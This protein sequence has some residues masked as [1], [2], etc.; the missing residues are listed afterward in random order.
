MKMDKRVKKLFA[1][2]LSIALVLP[3]IPAW[4]E[5]QGAQ[6][7]AL[8]ADTFVP[9]ADTEYIPIMHEEVLPEGVEFDFD[10][11]T[12]DELEE[13]GPR[14]KAVMDRTVWKTIVAEQFG[15]DYLRPYIK[16][17]GNEIISGSENRLTITE[18]DLYLPGKNGLDLE[19]KRRY[20]SGKY[21]AYPT[22]VYGGAGMVDSY[23]QVY[24]YRRTDTN[25]LIYIGFCTEDERNIYLKND[26]YIARL[27][28]KKQEE[29]KGQKYYDFRTLAGS[30][31]DASDETAVHVVYEPAEAPWQAKYRGE[32]GYYF[33]D[34]NLKSSGNTIGAGW[35]YVFPAA[36]IC[37]DERY[38]YPS[39]DEKEAEQYYS[40]IFQDRSGRVNS[41]TMGDG[42]VIGQEPATY[43][44]TITSENNNT[45]FYENF[46]TIQTLYENG[47]K[48]NYIIT[49][50]NGIK[51][52]MYS[53]GVVTES[54]QQLRTA[55]I[56]D[57]Y[58]NRIIFEYADDSSKTPNKIIDTYGREISIGENGIS[59]FNPELNQEQTVRYSVSTLP[60]E[61]LPNNSINDNKPVQ[62]LT[63][64]NEKGESTSYDAR[65]MQVIFSY[66]GSSHS[67]ERPMNFHDDLMETAIGYTL[68][69]ILYPTGAEVQYG[70]QPA[71]MR[72]QNKTIRQALILDRRTEL[73]NG[74]EQNQDTYT[75]SGTY[76]GL[77]KTKT[78]TAD[79][80]EI[81][82]E[83]DNNGLLEEQ[84]VYSGYTK[85]S[86]VT[87]SYNTNDL[88]L[89]RSTE[90]RQG[91][92]KT[93]EYT[94][95]NQNQISAMTVG[96]L[97]IG[98]NYHKVNNRVTDIPK[99]ITYQYK[100]GYYFRTDYTTSTALVPGK[101][102]VDTVKTVKSSDVK[103]QTKYEYDADGNVTAVYTWTEDKNNDGI[104]D[105]TDAYTVVN[106]SYGLTP[107]K[108]VTIRDQV[109]N[110]LDADGQNQGS[111]TADY[112]FNIFG[113]PTAR[114]DPYQQTTTVTYDELNRPVRYTFPNGGT[115]TIEYNLPALY[116]TVTD[117]QGVKLRYTYDGWGRVKKKQRYFNGEWRTFE[118]Y[119]YDAAGRV[120]E[121]RQYTAEGA[122]TETAYTYDGLDRVKTAAVQDLSGT[123]LYTE[124]YS[125]ENGRVITKTTTPADGGAAAAVSQTYDSQDRLI[126]EERSSGGTTY[127][128]KY[129]YDYQGRLLTEEDANGNI[130]SYTYDWRGNVIQTTD[131]AGNSSTAA[132]D[133]S[134][135]QIST[136]DP[137]G[138]TSFTVYDS[139][140]RVIRQETPFDGTNMAQT[141]Q[142]YDKNSNLIKQQVK[143]GAPG[144]G[145]KYRTTEYVYDAMG[146]PLGTISRDPAGDS[147][148][149]YTY[150]AGNRITSM[151]TGLTSYSETPAGGALT[152]YTYE[153][154]IIGTSDENLVKSRVSELVPFSFCQRASTI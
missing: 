49:D 32:S 92:S 121:A 58:G 40:G 60:A 39:G 153:H 46:Y 5:E 116:T 136:T 76:P 91:V 94:Y 147:V 89:T 123:A 26:G 43:R 6:T 102:A 54:R 109:D 38:V 63:V 101:Y 105:M 27:D 148:V 23:R 10:G 129:T 64:T 85:L 16:K 138:S 151:R 71:Y 74:I 7:A 4:A 3:G 11:Q 100:D 90:T 36:T 135:R 139:L 24:A 67:L 103:A 80:Q 34:R 84:T 134:G 22:A 82:E 18:T 13:T 70:Y 120:T 107:E 122:G 8:A 79:D 65:E 61:S 47:P 29:D 41:F 2:I 59:Y 44:S 19:I 128:W 33:I 111:V 55:A 119:T 77:T 98:Y 48:Y 106:S 37:R 118:D 154:A 108:T 95:V 143:S 130:T 88:T 99:T 45:L 72:N 146:N 81:V 9:D 83:Y 21:D 15:D 112:S 115:R 97:K 66:Y 73:V 25:A 57:D 114:T 150:D 52:Y 1:G 87:N 50:N 125:Y 56:A 17:E 140:D 104:L 20:D 145:D 133:L 124:A 42:C 110:V 144:E 30:L 35:E 12:L 126:K 137:K 131:P 152:Q 51:Y 127:T 31:S 141:K 69:R 68:E 93:T 132:Y 117:E 96:D 14:P 149:Q 75:F 28:S 62:R 113:S 86:S 78:R 53:G 142:Y